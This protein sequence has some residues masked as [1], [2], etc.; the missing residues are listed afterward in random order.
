[1]INRHDLDGSFSYEDRKRLYYVQLNYW[2]NVIHKLKINLVVFSETPHALSHFIIY[3]LCKKMGIQTIMLSYTTIPGLIYVKELFEA[4]P[5]IPIQSENHEELVQSIRS[6]IEKV[7]L[8]DEK[9][10]YMAV[11]QRKYFRAGV[12]IKLQALLFLIPFLL[13]KAK[14][15][16]RKI[17]NEFYKKKGFLFEQSDFTRSEFIFKRLFLRKRQSRLRKKYRSISKTPDTNKRYFY[18]PL[19]Y[20]PERSSCPEGSVYTDQQILIQMIADRLPPNM[21]LYVKEHPSQ[22]MMTRGA[23]GRPQFFYEDIQRNSQVVL[24]DDTFSS[25]ILIENSLAVITLTGTAGMEA[26]LHGRP[27]LLF[28]SAWYRQLPGAHYIEE[29]ADLDRAINQILSDS[30][31]S[32]TQVTEAL[33]EQAKFLFKGYLYESDMQTVTIS[34]PDHVTVLSEGLAALLKHLGYKENKDI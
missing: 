16:P 34:Y 24:V 11:Q 14:L 31:V 13:E 30:V 18:F 26:L 17:Y 12:V 2:L 27:A 20:Q 9:P 10:W 33:V 32:V 25:S 21:Y 22:Y 7:T 3:K 4:V 8:S 29:I 19:H 28:G 1:M 23:L 5:Y 15:L 6:Y